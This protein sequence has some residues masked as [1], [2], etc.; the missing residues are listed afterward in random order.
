MMSIER[1]SRFI[2][3]DV[4]AKCPMFDVSWKWID[5][6]FNEMPIEILR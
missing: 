4:I 3:Y 5:A 2:Q 1:I 6:L